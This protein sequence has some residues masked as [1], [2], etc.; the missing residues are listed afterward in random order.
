MPNILHLIPTLEGGGAE[1]QLAM[2][3]AEQAKRGWRVHVGVR[4]RGIYEVS[5]G[6]SGV[7]VHTLGD[8]RGINP[9][10]SARI[11]TLIAQVKPDVVHTWLPQMDV[12][13]GVAALW[14][15]VPWILSERTSTLAFKPFGFLTELR[16][17]LARY[18]CAV[19]ANS[20]GG[21]A[22]WRRKLGPGSYVTL[23]GNA[24]DT[25]AIR[26]ASA[27]DKAAHPN[28][29][30]LLVVGRLAPEKAVEIIIEAVRLLPAGIDF[31]MSII[32]DGP[33]RPKIEEMITTAGLQDRM[34]LMPFRPDWWGLLKN[35]QALL[36]MSRYEGQPNVVLET[37]AAE[38]PL[39][40]S[41]IPAHRE[42]LD[43]TSAT[44][45]PIDNPEA[46]AAA[47]IALLSDP[48]AARIRARRA[49]GA[50]ATM[51]IQLAADAYE[52][53][54]QKAINGMQE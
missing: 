20:A 24:I 51:T 4:R 9:L 46:L 8:Y 28:K 42:I 32:G 45:V 49:S 36:S 44:L 11:N 22:Y 3:A 53:I 34:S 16:H 43:E 50:V 10:L 21:A 48:V 18:S 31:S 5:L 33:L 27:E 30:Q 23:I 35:A 47:I 54:Y 1:R 12:V 6:A 39:I 14:N 41:D 38:C 52:R 7:T 29:P 17:V 13:G 25:D 40:V 37:M 19:V 2:L 26:R 15:S